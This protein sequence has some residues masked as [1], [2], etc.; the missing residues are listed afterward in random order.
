M[1]LRTVWFLLFPL[2]L[3][4]QLTEVP[5]GQWRAHLSYRNATS[6]AEVGDKIFCATDNSM[7]QYNWADNSLSTYTR[8]DGMSD[9]GI[10]FL[11]YCKPFETIIIGYENGNIDLFNN[12]KFINIPDIRIRNMTG[13]KRIN[14]IAYP[15]SGNFAYLATDFGI[16]ELNLAR[17]EIRNTFFIGLNGNQSQVLGVALN[18][19]FIFAATDRGVLQASR[20]AQNLLDF[21]NWQTITALGNRA[22]GGVAYW[23]NEL[24]TFRRDTLYAWNGNAVRFALPQ[25]YSFNISSINVSNNHLIITN[26]FRATAIDSAGNLFQTAADDRI[27]NP[28]FALMDKRGAIWLADKG[29][30]L[31]RMYF[32]E[33]LFFEPNGPFSSRSFS[34]SSFNRQVY[35]AAGGY[36]ASFTNNFDDNGFYRLKDGFWQS[37]SRR[38]MP[39]VLPNLFDAVF[40]RASPN[41]K[42]FYMASW[43]N[44][45]YEFED[46]KLIMH[47]TPANSSLQYIATTIDTSTGVGFLRVGGFDFDA[48]GNLWVVNSGVGEPLSVKRTNGNW[49]KFRLGSNTEPNKVMV[50]AVGQKWV[51]LRNGRLLVTNQ[52]V[53]SFRILTNSPGNG[54]FENGIVTALATDQDGAVW[55]GTEQGP[56]VFYSPSAISQ[57]RP[58]DGFRIRINQDGFVGFLLGSEIINDIYIDGANRKWFATNNGVWCMSADGSREVYRFNTANSPLLSNNVRAISVEGTSGEVFFVTDRGICSF[59]G[60]ATA[61]GAT[62][63][64]VR[65]FPNPVTADYEGVIAVSGLA[66]NAFV[67]ITDLNGQLVYQTRADGGQLNWNGRDYNNRKV[68]TGVYLVLSSTDDGSDTFVAKIMVVN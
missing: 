46:D 11:K 49:E 14:Y 40:V 29:G 7:F 32:F 68:N 4:A 6:I 13:S 53:S 33:Q 42:R 57:N 52:D 35:V 2:S 66:R 36:N 21:R 9:I 55:V 59:R 54:G 50:D 44:G 58:V 26:T 43:L 1:I 10:S 37:F 20:N 17:R 19:E 23:R 67:K 34:I 41:G 15:D 38:T 30:G 31:A 62:H 27:S 25:N 28:S 63:Q 16:V 51:M 18:Q 3:W 56:Y 65:V 8:I 12:G 22:V 64:N 48:Q 61:G 45:L 24:Y 60:S 39:Q 47:Y 5:I